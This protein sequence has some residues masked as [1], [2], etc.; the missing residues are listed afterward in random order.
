MTAR[1]QSSRRKVGFLCKIAHIRLSETKVKQG[2][3][4][5]MFLA[6]NA[7]NARERAPS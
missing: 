6:P 4:V 7:V 1:F 2:S 5:L 3:S